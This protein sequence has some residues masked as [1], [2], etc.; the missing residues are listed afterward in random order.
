MAM[1][2]ANGDSCPNPEAK[3]IWILSKIEENVKLFSTL[4]S[5]AEFSTPLEL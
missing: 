4:Q 1:Q 3:W 2:R 5:G